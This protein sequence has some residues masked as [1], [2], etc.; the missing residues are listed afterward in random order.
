MKHISTILKLLML[1]FLGAALLSCSIQVVD[2]GSLKSSERMRGVYHRVKPGE[3]LWRISRAYNIDLQELA[4]I[5]NITDSSRISAGSVVFVPDAPEVVDIP[6]ARQAA[7]AKPPAPP[8]AEKPAAVAAS[9]ESAR[10]PAAAAA[11]GPGKVKEE[12]ITDRPLPAGTDRGPAAA[13]KSREQAPP[14]P[15][16]K[17]DASTTPP[18]RG[19]AARPPERPEAAVPSAAREQ[20]AAKPPAPAPSARATDA[21]LK[22]RTA[23]TPPPA[24]KPEAAQR[25]EEPQGLIRMDKGRFAW[26]V[27][28][29]VITR[30]GI[31]PSGMKYNGIK[32][33][34]KENTTVQAAAAGTVIYASYVKGYGETVIVKHD[35]SYT[36][37][38]AY[39][40]N[41]VAK[42][43]ERIRKGDRLASIGPSQE[44]GGEPYL[45]FEIREKNKARNPLFF[46]P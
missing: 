25:A 3:T 6:P 22:D 33:A 28:G 35:E 31:Q 2:R 24:R 32:I 18:S 30:F 17:T 11:G 46:L 10:P 42:R 45:Y 8:P 5:N 9:P 38:Y 20:M 13:G 12:S 43:D 7:E 34:A 27:R 39:L 16:E 14:G 44:P 21:A 36:T 40:K 29:P 19:P 1:A 15:A 26:P 23:V 37:V 41:T 4:E